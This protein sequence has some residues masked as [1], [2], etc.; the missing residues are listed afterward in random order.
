M[1]IFGFTLQYLSG[2]LFPLSYLLFVVLEGL[3]DIGDLW[4][5][6]G[7]GLDFCG[8]ESAEVPDRLDV[9]SSDEL[10]ETTRPVSRT[11]S[12]TV[13]LVI[14][15]SP[16]PLTAPNHDSSLTTCW[17][18]SE[19]A[20]LLQEWSSQPGQGRRSLWRRPEAPD[21]FQKSEGPKCILCLFKHTLQQNM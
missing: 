4:R 11:Q 21:S 15:V 1:V 18:R 17:R 12:C 16:P 5:A 19:R 8:G 13:E 10:P 9:S 6:N 14:R 2:Q 20:Q 7:K 3:F